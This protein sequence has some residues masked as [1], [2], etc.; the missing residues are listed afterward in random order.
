[1]ANSL[2]V[3]KLEQ[4]VKS[5]YQ[6]VAEEPDEGYHFEMGRPLAERLGYPP[7]HLD[8]I[9]AEA[10]ESFAGVGY[11]FDLAAIEDGD[12]VLDLG[13]GS[14]TDVFVAALHVGDDGSVTGLDMTV[15]Q[16]EKARK[17]RDEAGLE[18]V[19]FE[20]GYIE[21]VP[22]D[23][24]A[25]DVVVSNGVINLS[26]DKAQVFE[27]AH[28]VLAPGGR[29][30]ISDIISEEVMPESIKNDEDLWAACIGGA[31]QIDRYTTA[32]EA[33]GFAVTDVRDNSQYEFI[34]DRAANACE[35]Y[36]VKS[37]TLGATK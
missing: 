6:D 24:G 12:D 21:D 9:P 11:Y 36:G 15:Q 23:D 33:A 30:A 3:D 31:E 4:A 1:M 26:P 29:L 37:V 32:I 35:K 16:L 17:L 19:S 28:R 20:Q 25:F 7:E 27:E 14:G 8:R 5:V 22:F 34:S 2:D 18:N 13:S 10:M